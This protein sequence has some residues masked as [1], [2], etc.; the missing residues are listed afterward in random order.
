M[1]STTIRFLNR[2]K[3]DYISLQSPVWHNNLSSIKKQIKKNI[4]LW[5]DQIEILEDKI[6]TSNYTFDNILQ[7]FDRLE[8]SLSILK[9]FPSIDLY[10]S[11]FATQSLNLFHYATISS[12]N[13]TLSSELKENITQP[14]INCTLNGN[15]V[16]FSGIN[17]KSKVK[18]LEIDRK[19]F[20]VIKIT[21]NSIKNKN[22]HL[23]LKCRFITKQELAKHVLSLP[24]FWRNYH[25]ITRDSLNLH[26]DSPIDINNFLFNFYQAKLINKNKSLPSKKEIFDNVRIINPFQLSIGSFATHLIFSL[27]G[28]VLPLT[29]REVVGLDLNTNSFTISLNENE[30][31]LITIDTNYL[32]VDSKSFLDAFS[33]EFSKREHAFASYFELN[34]YNG[35]KYIITNKEE[36]G[37]IYETNMV[38]VFDSLTKYDNLYN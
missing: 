16:S 37:Y 24:E 12:L 4:L 8:L 34:N 1:Y 9:C 3:S 25:F 7:Y 5:E 19:E 6:L 31:N 15:A 10:S 32:G 28:L 35:G 21:D 38:E 36:I 14:D 13:Q 11:F 26:Q 30:V 20:F 29:E 23:F 17:Y 22:Q 33:E 18:P 2:D 27:P